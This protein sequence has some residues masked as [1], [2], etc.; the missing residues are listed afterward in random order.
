MKSE[1]LDLMANIYFMRVEENISNTLSFLEGKLDL[2]EK[3]ITQKKDILKKAKK[4]DSDS[5]GIE[6]NSQYN[7]YF[8]LYER[9]SLQS[10]STLTEKDLQETA[11]NHK[12]DIEGFQKRFEDFKD[13]IKK[14]LGEELTH[15]RDHHPGELT[16]CVGP[17][18]TFNYSPNSQILL[19]TMKGMYPD[20]Q[21]K[22]PTS[23]SDKLT[24]L[25]KESPLRILE[26]NKILTPN[27]VHQW[28]RL[29][30]RDD[31]LYFGCVKVSNPD[32]PV[33]ANGKSTRS[34]GQMQGTAPDSSLKRKDL[35]EKMDAL[36]PGREFRTWDRLVQ[37]LHSTKDTSSSRWR[38]SGGYQRWEDLKKALQLNPN[39]INSL[40]TVES[41]ES[42]GKNLAALLDASLA[43]SCEAQPL[44]PDELVLINAEG[45]IDLEVA[46][47]SGWYSDNLVNTLRLHD[48][49]GFCR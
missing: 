38:I 40:K 2:I 47:K 11:N 35:L 28:L 1:I 26:L 23:S 16:L 49:H 27:D 6:G 13:R 22:K 4:N 18:Y 39:Q 21:L 29:E 24:K 8:N 12:V 5:P 9:C 33:V 37:Q 36:R 10:S 48:T 34:L 20:E 17:M 44:V 3:I 43:T 19:K 15:P 14:L 7:H 41:I 42:F 30:T 31:D 25:E 32:K 45:E 46:E